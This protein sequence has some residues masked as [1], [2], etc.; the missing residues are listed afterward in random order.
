MIKSIFKNIVLVL[1]ATLLVENTI[2]QTRRAPSDEEL[3]TTP[4]QADARLGWWLD[5]RYGMFVHWSVYSNL[6]GTWNGR[7]YGGYV[8][9]FSEWRKSLFLFTLRR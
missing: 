8:S 2:A 5:A 9:T 3:R 6:S 4:E 7:A 1:L